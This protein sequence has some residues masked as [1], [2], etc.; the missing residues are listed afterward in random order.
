VI[1]AFLTAATLLLGSEG[2][3]L[4][5]GA[6][7]QK[8]AVVVRTRDGREKRLPTDKEQ[9]GISNVAVSADHT[10]VGW[11]ALYPNCCTSYPIPLKLIV[12]SGGRVHQFGPNELPLWY[13]VFRNG[14][15]EVAFHQ[16]TVHGGLGARYE[17]RDVASGRLLA[18][19]KPES[20]EPPPAWVNDLE[21]HHSRTAG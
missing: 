1:T 3:E 18:S 21:A 4:Y 9:V 12:Y 14:S 15:R 7:W 5:D 17:L 16:E 20:G 8:D 2:G 19:F 10:A 11:L 6:T 13:W